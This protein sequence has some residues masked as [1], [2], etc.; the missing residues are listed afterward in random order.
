ML[1]YF[2]EQFPFI[3]KTTLK[4]F[5]LRSSYPL[6][7]SCMILIIVLCVFTP[8]RTAVDLSTVVPNRGAAA[9]LGA[10]QDTQGCR[11]LVRFSICH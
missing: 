3:M 10:I 2:Y 1:T 7:K 8:T 11:K 5:S 9:P 4:F 6:E